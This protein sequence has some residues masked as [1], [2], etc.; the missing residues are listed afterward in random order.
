MS[1]PPFYNPDL[2]PTHEMMG[3]CISSL[4]EKADVARLKV[5][6]FPLSEASETSTNKRIKVLL[7]GKFQSHM[8]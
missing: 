6:G 7:L 4:Q 5:V 3:N 8:H 2:I 1:T